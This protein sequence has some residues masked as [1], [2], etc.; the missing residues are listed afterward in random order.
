MEAAAM[1]NRASR[2]RSRGVTLVELMIVVVVVGILT[3][4]ALP[5][6]RSYMIR[7]KRTDAKAELMRAASRLERCFTR[8][9]DYRTTGQAP[10]NDVCYTPRTLPE[11]TYTITGDIQQ[12]TFTLTATPINGQAEDT[13]C[14]T[15]TLDQTGLQSATG[16]ATPQ[17]CWSGS[18]G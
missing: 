11:N 3:A 12:L 7:V 18:G 1:I 8:T 4:I 10:P 9:N 13:K 5:G 15:F 14:A 17:Q 16:S 2:L 6:Y